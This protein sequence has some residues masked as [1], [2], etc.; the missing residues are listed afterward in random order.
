MVAIEVIFVPVAVFAPETN[1]FQ[2]SALKTDF[3]QVSTPEMNFFQVSATRGGLY[4]GVSHTGRTIFWCQPHGA[5]Y[6]LVS[7]PG[8]VNYIGIYVFVYIVI[9]SLTFRLLWNIIYRLC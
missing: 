4:F 3:F 7:A 8:A 6:I 9:F 1:F 5:D 2:V